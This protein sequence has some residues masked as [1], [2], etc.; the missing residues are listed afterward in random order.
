LIV[1]PR[2]FTGRRLRVRRVDEEGFAEYVRERALKSGEWVVDVDHGG[3]V[4]NSYG[5]PAQTECVLAVSDP[6]GITVFWCSRVPANK[7]T[8]RGAADACVTG[9]GDLFDERVTAKARK[10]QAM[11]WI[12]HLHRT[13][14]PAM[15]AI[16]A[17]S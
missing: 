10:E 13:E 6:L 14:V 8:L 15:V 9:A 4:A 5:Y 2:P 17:V 11:A 16:A 12:K 3:S 1:T 7:V